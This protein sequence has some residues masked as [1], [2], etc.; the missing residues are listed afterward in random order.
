MVDSFQFTREVRLGLT[1]LKPQNDAENPET[2]VS[3]SSAPSEWSQVRRSE[4]T[5]CPFL[6]PV[7][8]RAYLC[9]AGSDECGSAAESVLVVTEGVKVAH[10]SR[11]IYYIGPPSVQRRR[12]RG[13]RSERGNR[14]LS[15]RRDP[16]VHQLGAGRCSS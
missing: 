1:H 9:K 15:D 13:E 3:A 16:G 6:L 10:L 14:A 11:P 5:R 7:S 8:A 2:A 4:P 12:R